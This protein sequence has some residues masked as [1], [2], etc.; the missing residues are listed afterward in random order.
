[1]LF[2][3][4]IFGI[5]TV[6]LGLTGLAFGLLLVIC[7]ILYVLWHGL[8]AGIVLFG[9]MCPLSVML[10]IGALRRTVKRGKPNLL[11]HD[12]GFLQEAENRLLRV[13]STVP[14]TKLKPGR[15]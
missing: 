12:G 4:I 15:R 6:C 3:R 7:L 9:I 5:L 8:S 2:N 10:A 13:S 1:M 14:A 11:R